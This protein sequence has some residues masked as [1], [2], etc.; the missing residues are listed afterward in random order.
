VTAAQQ[1]ADRLLFCLG[2][3]LRRK[4]FTTFRRKD[5][6]MTVHYEMHDKTLRSDTCIDKRL[7]TFGF[8]A[9]S[10]CEVSDSRSEKKLHNVAQS[11]V[12]VCVPGGMLGGRM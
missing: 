6:L 5:A 12:S 11:R 9:L 2:S 8:Y 10:D 7:W 4:S 3:T 1:T